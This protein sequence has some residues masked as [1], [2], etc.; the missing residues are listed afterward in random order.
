MSDAKAGLL[1]RTIELIR[2]RPASLNYQDIA[3][4]A[5][6][7]YHFIVSLTQDKSGDFG[8]RKVQKVHDYLERVHAT[9]FTS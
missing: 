3:H 2:N 5:G 4:N 6:V 1:D 8:V 7:N 9:V